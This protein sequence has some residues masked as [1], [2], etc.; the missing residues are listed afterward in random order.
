VNDMKA[1]I[2]FIAMTCTFAKAEEVE[3]WHGWMNLTPCSTLEW[4]NDGPFG[5]PSPTY[6]S[7][8]QELHT[9]IVA[10]ITTPTELM[11]QVKNDCIQCGVQGAAAAG[12]AALASEGVAGWPVFTATFWACLQNRTEH[13]AAV[14]SIGWRQNSMCT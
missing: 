13:Y 4:T 11:N 9:S 7:S 5:T 12:A 1:L 10:D 6:R 2:V 3:V 14:K 8:P